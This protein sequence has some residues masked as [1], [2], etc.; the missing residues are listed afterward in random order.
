MLTVKCL[1]EQL[2]SQMFAGQSYVVS[3]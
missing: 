1:F 3:L 2:C